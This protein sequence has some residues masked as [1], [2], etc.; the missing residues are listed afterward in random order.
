VYGS[1]LNEVGTDM[2]IK[3]ARLRSRGNTLNLNPN[4]YNWNAG[5]AGASATF[6]IGYTDIVALAGGQTDG[7]VSCSLTYEVEGGGQ[8]NSGLTIRFYLDSSNPAATASDFETT[9]PEP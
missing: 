3:K 4:P 5:N 6:Q 7:Y 2:E 8:Y 9:I 1:D